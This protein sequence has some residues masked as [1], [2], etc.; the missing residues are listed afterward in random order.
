VRLKDDLAMPDEG[1]HYRDGHLNR[2]FAP[3]NAGK[4]RQTLL[5]EGMGK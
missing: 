3:E 1:A 5:G 4:H 2:A